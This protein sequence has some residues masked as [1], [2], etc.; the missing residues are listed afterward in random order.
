MR[1]ENH[2]YTISGF[3]IDYWCLGVKDALLK[4]GDR[5]KYEIFKQHVE[6]TFGEKFEEIS[7]EQAQA[8]VFGAVDYASSLGFQPH[9]D[10]ERGTENFDFTLALGPI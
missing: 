1:C 2:N 5:Q 10:F 7:L 3:L 9:A 8:I 4:K 6:N